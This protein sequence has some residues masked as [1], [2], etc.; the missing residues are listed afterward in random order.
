MAV[1]KKKAAPKKAAPAVKAAPA[2]ETVE[3]P[4]PR[5]TRAA[6]RGV[7]PLRTGDVKLHHLVHQTWAAF[8]PPDYTIED[9]E[10]PKLYS[11]MSTRFQD[12]DRIEVTAED[13]SFVAK[14]IVR[15]SLG[16]EINVQIYEMNE[17]QA[18]MMGKELE[19]YGYL[20]RH[21]GAVKKFWIQN[22]DTGST[23]KEGMNTQME[24]IQYLTDFIKAA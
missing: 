2:A 20:I 4:E 8:V 15:R 10:N 16:R 14:G 5:E 24:A 11:F 17:L 12:L 7:V 23:L 21:G 6:S 13:G 19:M 1:A 22:K 9:L 3:T 18:P